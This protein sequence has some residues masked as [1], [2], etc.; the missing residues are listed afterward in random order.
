MLAV[1]PALM[2]LK[3]PPFIEAATPDTASLLSG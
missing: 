2:P 3:V 1:V